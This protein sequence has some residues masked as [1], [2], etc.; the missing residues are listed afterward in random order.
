[1]FWGDLYGCAGDNPQPPV[2]QLED[3]IRARTLFGY[4]ETRDYWDHQNCVGWVRVGDKSHDGCA[5]VL[6]N[7]DE[8]GYA[9]CSKICNG[10][11]K[12]NKQTLF[13]QAE[14]YGNREGECVT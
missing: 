10:D 12:D 2:S 6:C 7:G 4:G 1:M 9:K 14:A 8:D 11:R 5:V 13:L 3:L